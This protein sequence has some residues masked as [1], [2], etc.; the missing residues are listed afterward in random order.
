MSPL[1]FAIAVAMQM[2]TDTKLPYSIS[3]LLINFGDIYSSLQN[4]RDLELLAECQMPAH[5]S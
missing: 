1:T 2:R 5:H 4:L 3:T